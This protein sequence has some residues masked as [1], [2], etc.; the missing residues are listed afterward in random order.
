LQAYVIVVVVVMNI[1]AK[2]G[3]NMEDERDYNNNNR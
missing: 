2:S 1:T 3:L